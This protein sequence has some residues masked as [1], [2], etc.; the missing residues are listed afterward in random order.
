V[1]GGPNSRRALEIA[2]MLAAPGAGTVTA[3]HVQGTRGDPARS[4]DALVAGACAHTSLPRDRC[5]LRV[6]SSDDPRSAILAA[7]A[8]ADLVVLGATEGLW[9]R[10]L[11][12]GLSEDIAA[13]CSTAVAIVRRGRPRRRTSARQG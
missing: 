1:A 6:V 5:T 11:A 2:L 10:V 12:T 4:V 8:E 9:R 7:A 13:C 3:L